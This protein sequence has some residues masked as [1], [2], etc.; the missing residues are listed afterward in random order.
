[1]KMMRLAKSRMSFDITSEQ[2]ALVDV[3]RQFAREQLAPNAAQWDAEARFP[4]DVI[5]QA[6]ELGFLGLYT[7]QSAGGLGLGRLT[8]SMIIEELAAGCT[9]TTAYMTIHN[10]ALW[11]IATYGTET[12]LTTFVPDLVVGKRLASYCLTEPEAGSDAASMRTE[13]KL[14]GDHYILNGTKAFI[15]GAGATDVLVVMARSSTSSGTSDGIA[16][17]VVEGDTD[18]VSYGDN[19]LKMGWRNQPTRQVFFDGVRVPQS[20]RLGGPTDGFMIAMKG[21]DGGRINIAA[22]STGTAQAALDASLAYVKT[23][24]QFGR[25]IGEFQA[26]QFRLA[27]MATDLL[28]ARQMIRLAAHRLDQQHPEATATAAMAK[29]FATDAGFKIC[30]EALQLHGGYGY[31]QSLPLERH[32]RDTRVHQILEGTNEIMRM[33]VG[34]RLMLADNMD[35]LA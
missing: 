15:S 22:C 32:V 30:N 8:S 3:A 18:G 9:S 34:R 10:M 28:A 21:L 20:H 4:V 11:M 26:L 7:P 1:M 17:F 35:F 13:A 25:P 27:D 14:E 31:L 16:S 5:K 23:R 12:A 6:G 19:E 29:R 33:I 24:R 2:Q